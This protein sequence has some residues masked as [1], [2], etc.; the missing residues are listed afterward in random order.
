VRRFR[1]TAR[2]G[3]M[4]RT[5]SHVILF[6]V[7]A[8]ALLGLLSGG[9]AS[10][11]ICKIEKGPHVCVDI[12]GGV[13]VS[14]SGTDAFIGVAALYSDLLVTGAQAVGKRG[15]EISVL[16]LCLGGTVHVYYNLGAPLGEGT[17]T[18]TGIPCAAPYGRARS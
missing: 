7:L 15:T 6:A 3:D 1:T 16:A 17:D 13:L 8:A 5:I 14:V 2:E 10:A 11:E 9:T 4:R 12:N 18:D